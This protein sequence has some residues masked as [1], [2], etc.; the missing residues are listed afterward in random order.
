MARVLNLGFWMLLAHTL[1]TFAPAG[2]PS[3]NKAYGAFPQAGVVHVNASAA[4]PPDGNSCDTGYRTIQEGIRQARLRG[5]LIVEVCDSSTY[6]ENVA[7]GGGIG[8]V[9][10]AS[11]SLAA[12]FTYLDV[13]ARCTGETGGLPQFPTIDGGGFFAPVV[14]ILGGPGKATVAGFRIT[15]GGDSG[16][17]VNDIPDVANLEVSIV[18]NCIDDNRARSGAGINIEKAGSVEISRNAIHNN[19]AN[20]AGGGIHFRRVT[21]SVKTDRNLISVNKAGTNGGGISGLFDGLTPASEFSQH[22]KDDIFSNDA[23]GFGGGAS[24]SDWTATLS[25]C[26]FIGNRALESGGGGINFDVARQCQVQLCQFLSCR[27][28]D[29][30]PLP[31]PLQLWA[32]EQGGGAIRLRGGSLD[33]FG[34]TIDS[35]VTGLDGGGVVYLNKLNFPAQNVIS[36]ASGSVTNTSFVGGLAFDD[37]GGLSIQVATNLTVTN[38]SLSRNETVLGF[39]GG[40]HT[41]CAAVSTLN[42]VTVSNNT[43]GIDGG[44]I[45]LRDAEITVNESNLSFNHARRDGGGMVLESN[46][47]P[48]F[49]IDMPICHSIET[50]S[51]MTNVGW[52]GNTS[53]NRAG[54]FGVKRFDVDRTI[55]FLIDHNT[56]I[57]NQAKDTTEAAVEVALSRQ[58]PRTKTRSYFRNCIFQNRGPQIRGIARIEPVS[59]FYDILDCTFI[60]DTAPLAGESEPIG[61][62]LVKDSPSIGRDRFTGPVTVNG[63]LGIKATDP[64]RKGGKVDL[65]IEDSI[66]ENLTLG[67][68]VINTGKKLLPVSVEGCSFSGGVTGIQFNK[69]HGF[70]KND[71]FSNLTT[72]I[73]LLGGTTLT[74]KGSVTYTNVATPEDATGN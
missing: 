67:L 53:A 55:N 71:A 1:L 35:C 61:I 66:F 43:S 62:D 64:K 37:G 31:A 20:E 41:T 18:G 74:K 19:T 45:Y 8:L 5:A 59:D 15:R 9:S 16:I 22:V 42:S 26:T 52:F 54:A 33:I 11:S 27:A 46:E 30:T 6:P 58:P 25:E 65:V 36:Q 7:M 51:R 73:R 70:L 34:G 29:S 24:F 23:T 40:I 39:G 72:G 50:L 10:K 13:L 3:V 12:N 21:N 2:G 28:G 69:V 17:R 60:L 56:F 63:G 14:S 48:S 49:I 4:L 57:G 47:I 32:V 38:V 68:D 44:G